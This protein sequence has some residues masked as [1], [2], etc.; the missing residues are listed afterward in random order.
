MDSI[1]L[2]MVPDLE[3]FSRPVRYLV[4]TALVLGPLLF[5]A[6]I[7]VGTASSPPVVVEATVVDSPPADNGDVYQLAGFSEEAP[8]RTAVEEALRDGS[9]SVTA[10]VEEVRSDPEFYVQHD[11]QVVRVT[12]TKK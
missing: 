2:P 5:A 11:E 6:A 1:G 10:T 3:A 9:G 4:L 7:L 8:T 12:V